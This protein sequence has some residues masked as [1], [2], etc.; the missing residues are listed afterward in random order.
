MM[1]VESAV[2]EAADY[3]AYGSGN[4]HKD[5]VQTTYDAMVER[6]CVASAHLTD[7]EPTETGC[8]NPAVRVWLTEVNGT[9]IMEVTGVED[10]SVCADPERSPGPCRVRVELDYTF[11]L[12]APIAI[13]VGG[14]RFGLPKSLPFQRDSVFAVSDF[15]GTTP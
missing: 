8:T 15:L 4:C 11:D 2:R 13:E 6:A 7:Y 3:G 9:D 14:H 5:N 1:T 10:T 12:I